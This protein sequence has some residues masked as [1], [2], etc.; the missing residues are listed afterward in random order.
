VLECVGK[1]SGGLTVRLASEEV[2]A[3]RPVVLDTDGK[4]VLLDVIDT[5]LAEPSFAAI[6]AGASCAVNRKTS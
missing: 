5:W 3:T 6:P 1:H 2:G 4:R